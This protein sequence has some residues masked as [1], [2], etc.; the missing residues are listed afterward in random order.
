MDARDRIESLRRH[1][2]SYTPDAHGP[3]VYWGQK[4]RD[5]Q[6]WRACEGESLQLRHARVIADRC[7]TMPFCIMP[8]ELTVSNR[9]GTGD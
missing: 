7:R 5:A 9:H 8:G 3:W 2:L 4:I 1:A 6:V